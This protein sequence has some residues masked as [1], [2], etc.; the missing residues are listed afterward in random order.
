MLCVVGSLSIMLGP[1]PLEIDQP[2]AGKVSINTFPCEMQTVGCDRVIS[3]LGCH[4]E[5]LVGPW[6]L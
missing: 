1:G 4:E 6:W 2:V 5:T 3:Y